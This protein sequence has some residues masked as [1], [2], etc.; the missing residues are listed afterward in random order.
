M[1]DLE[2]YIVKV[3]G[4]GH[5]TNVEQLRREK[6]AAM[7]RYEKKMILYRGAIESL[8]RKL[9]NSSRHGIFT[10]PSPA[11]SPSWDR[12]SQEQAMVSPEMN[13]IISS[14]GLTYSP[15]PQCS[16]GLSFPNTGFYDTARS[17]TFPI[18][19]LM[20]E[21]NEHQGARAPYSLHSITPN[22]YERPNTTVS[23]YPQ[24]D[25][26]ERPLSFQRDAAEILEVPLQIQNYQQNP[27]LPQE[28]LSPPVGAA[29]E[30]KSDV[31]I[32]TRAVTTHGLE[33]QPEEEDPLAA[34]ILGGTVPDQDH[35]NMP[36]FTTVGTRNDKGW[37]Q[38]EDSHMLNPQQN[39]GMYSTV[40][41]ID[42]HTTDKVTGLYTKAGSRNTF[43]LSEEE[44][45]KQ[46]YLESLKEIPMNATAEQDL[47]WMN[48]IQNDDLFTPGNRNTQASFELPIQGINDEEYCLPKPQTE[49]IDRRQSHLSPIPVAS[50]LEDL[51]IAGEDIRYPAAHDES[52]TPEVVEV[53]PMQV[54]SYAPIKKVHFVPKKKLSR[55]YRLL[56]SLPGSSGKSNRLS[57]LGSLRSSS[58]Q[59]GTLSENIPM[60]DQSF[61]MS[62]PSHPLS[63]RES[64]TSPDVVDERL[65]IQRRHAHITYKSAPGAGDYSPNFSAEPSTN[66]P[67][68]QD[69][70]GSSNKLDY[71]FIVTEQVY[72][73]I[74]K[75]NSFPF[76]A[77]DCRHVIYMCRDSF[78]VFSVPTPQDPGPVKA[79]FSYRLGEAEG[80]KRGKVPWQY[81]AG[82]ASRRHIATISKQRVCWIELYIVLIF[83]DSK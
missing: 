44:T 38:A 18:T 3:A 57:R 72:K 77:L 43:G 62:S 33:I 17:S 7:A 42:A 63:P 19:D 21:L 9:Q 70:L 8:H 30:A 29:N 39:T 51:S 73:L 35:E 23:G 34:S 28:E 15:I 1:R 61:D 50:E 13:G 2:S 37:G 16:S 75:E 49:S 11:V 48:V 69:F 58:S 46:P 40:S 14:R 56:A 31:D 36:P 81:R 5:G 25:R 45:R 54:S 52:G 79:R 12:S 47:T 83:T 59:S 80:L 78:Q 10:D 60:N 32:Y 26:L 41:D 76:L 68:E 53:I 74:P 4:S 24:T 71:E 67:L 66:P 22:V 65:A 82:A 6:R 27:A 20:D 55:A 64:Q